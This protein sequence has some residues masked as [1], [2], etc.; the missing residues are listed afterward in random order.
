MVAARAS[1]RSGGRDAQIH[2]YLNTEKYA[3][4]LDS[5]AG[6]GRDGSD[7]SAYLNTSLL[8]SP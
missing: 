8:C 1:D 2:T 6:G 5:R 7:E 4:D 3:S